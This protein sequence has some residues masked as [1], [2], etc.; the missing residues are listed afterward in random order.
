MSCHEPVNADP[1]T[2]TLKKAKALG[3]LVLTVTDNYE[4]PL[5]PNSTLSLNKEEMGS[6]QCTQCHSEN[7]KITPSKGILI[8]HKVHEEKEIQC[9]ACHNRVAHNESGDWEPVLSDP[10]GVKSVKHANYMTMT[11]CFRCHTLTNE[12]PEGGIKAP[13]KCSACHPADFDLKPSNHDAKDFYPAGHAKLATAKVDRSTGRPVVA[14]ESA[15]EETTAAE[16]AEGEAEGEAAEAEGAEGE[17]LNLLAVD[18][19]NYCSTCHVIDKFCADCHGMEMPHPEEFKTKTHPELVKTKLDKCD[20]CHQVKK[21]GYLFCNNCHHGSASK[22]T[23]DPKVK[24]TTQHAKAVTTNGVAGCLGTCHEQKFCVDCHTKLKPVPTSHKDAKWLRDKLTVTAYGSTAAAPSGKHALAAGKAIDSCEVCHGAG[25]T[26]SAFCKGCHGMDMP[27]PDT[28]KKNHVS[29]SKTPKLCAN[30]H[31]FKELCSDCHHKD[32]KNGIAWVKQHPKAIAA[33]GAA[34]CFEKCH[35]DKQFCVSC[36]TKLKAVPASHNAKNWT[37][38][39]ALK[40]AAGHSTAYKAQTDSCDYC[41]GT[42]GV[43]A[44]F[45]KSCHVLPMPHPANFKDTHKADFAAKK[46]TKKSCENCH[47]TFFCDN[48]HHTGSVANQPWRTYHPNLVKKNGAQPCF[49]CHE[50]TF[51][52]YCHVRL[53]H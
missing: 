21:T 42:G 40:K 14:A 24:W 45:C 29:G 52:S 46:L 13:G 51:C 8:D 16:G 28:F 36:H 4:L 3:E 37:R 9:T 10:E 50:P 18:N 2:F 6:V 15:S 44:K 19:V 41:H 34:Q 22:W 38:D 31:T 35:E 32:A 12:V 23:Y 33:G 48:C 5:N 20:L 30:C 39:L 53:I 1:I 27:H 49:K 43:E 25:G 11:A 7:R 26:G 17:A 47:N